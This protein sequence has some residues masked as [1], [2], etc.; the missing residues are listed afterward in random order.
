LSMTLQKM[1]HRLDCMAASVPV[2]RPVFRPGFLPARAR[3]RRPRLLCWPHNNDWRETMRMQ[4]LHV[5][6]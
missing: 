4:S 5:A 2:F 1:S 3:A 6:R